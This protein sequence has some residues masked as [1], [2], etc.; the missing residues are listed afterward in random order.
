MLNFSAYQ[1]PSFLLRDLLSVQCFCSS[2]F[3]NCVKN[4]K[5]INDSLKL[6]LIKKTKQLRSTTYLL[7]FMN[8]V[9]RLLIFFVSN[10]I[11]INMKQNQQHFQNK[12]ITQ[13]GD[14]LIMKRFNPTIHFIN[15]IWG[16]C[17]G[18]ENENIDQGR[19]YL[20]NN[21]FISHCSFSRS[22]SFNSD[23]G[24]IYVNGGS[25]SMNVNYS[26]FYNCVANDYTASADGGAIYFSSTSSYLRMICANRCHAC[27]S[28][29]FAYLYASQIN[30]VE[31]LSVSYC[32][33]SS[34]GSYSIHLQLGDQRAD[35]LNSSMN[36]AQYFSGIGIHAPSSFSSSHC[37]CS[38]NKA[39]GYVCIY[40]F[41]ASG[42][43]TISSANIVQNNSPSI[44]VFCAE[45]IGQKKMLYCIFQ[46]NQN[47]LF[48]V[49]SG[50][51]EVSH[52]YINHLSSSLLGNM[53]VSL[54]TNNSFLEITTYQ[55]QF[56]NSHYCNTDIP[57]P[58]RTLEYTPMRSLEETISRTNYETI[59]LTQ[60]RT[61]ENTKSDTL[62]NTLHETLINTLQET[63]MNTL[64]ETPSDTLKE[65][66]S[67]T[68][69]VTMKETPTV[70]IHRSYAECIFTNPKANK[71]EINVIFSFS[72]IYPIAILMLS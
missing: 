62:F 25:F 47:F 44:G 57:L 51:L 37:T 28:Y 30:H 26:M 69:Q 43:I 36:N 8:L 13:F 3:F 71:K 22:S 49:N 9:L 48:C 18:C 23:G 50:S 1:I 34:S 38:N 35:N 12:S 16:V 58:P 70:S 59:R 45:G 40:F 61:F 11:G 53:A 5:N 65:S 42:S 15:L 32:S 39:N 54:S 14:K 31:Y 56:F 64:K 68:L 10:S 33:Y 52:S 4:K 67:N 7:T 41:S 17:L 20:D 6:Y 66:L 60:Q 24:V 29:H 46:N 19:S 63:P 2:L 55:I 72:F 27:S 21:I